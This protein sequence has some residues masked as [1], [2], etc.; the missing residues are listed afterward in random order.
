MMMRGHLSAIRGTAGK[1]FVDMDT[2]ART[3]EEYM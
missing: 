3:E 2:R 1:N